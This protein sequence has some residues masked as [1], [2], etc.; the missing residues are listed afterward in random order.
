MAFCL[1]G[2]NNS[3]KIQ[4]LLNKLCVFFSEPIPT[5]PGQDFGAENRELVE[6]YRDMMESRGLITYNDDGHHFIAMKRTALFNLDGL[7]QVG[8]FIMDIAGVLTDK[9][10]AALPDR[11]KRLLALPAA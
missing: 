5:R 1:P 4:K 9:Q 2:N 8:Q 7:F 10:R 6:R 11:A 3:V